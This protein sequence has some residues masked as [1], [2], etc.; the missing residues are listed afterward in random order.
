MEC[1][2]KNAAHAMSLLQKEHLMQTPQVYG[3]HKEI[4]LFSPCAPGFALPA[5]FASQGQRHAL[6][7]FP[8]AFSNIHD[9]LCVRSFV[10]FFIFS[11]VFYFF[12]WPS[13]PRL[14][15]CIP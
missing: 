11:S 3:V 9:A 7:I 14:F 2:R 8:C 10:F 1:E 12:L 5:P 6:A 15:R 4:F 13:G